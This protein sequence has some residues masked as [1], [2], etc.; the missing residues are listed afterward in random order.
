MEKV[1]IKVSAVTYI[2]LVGFIANEFP[3]RRGNYFGCDKYHVLNMWHENLKHLIET[4]VLQK[5]EEIEGMSFGNGIVITD[6]KIPK[7]FLNDKMC[8]TGDG[9][10]DDIDELYKFFYKDFKGLDCMCCKEANMIS[11]FPTMRTMGDY[12]I[13]LTKGQCRICERNIYTNNDEEITEKEFFTL[14]KELDSLMFKK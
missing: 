14:S 3:M 2:S 9:G 13:N 6:S 4:G 11:Y 10:V 7:D 12:P 1:K 8:F 5:D